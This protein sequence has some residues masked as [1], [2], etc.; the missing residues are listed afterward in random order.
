MQSY[1]MSCYAMLFLCCAM[2][3]NVMSYYMLLCFEYVFAMSQVVL[4]DV[5]SCCFMQAA[6]TDIT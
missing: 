6:Y 2:F 3:C 5:T 4:C 1:V